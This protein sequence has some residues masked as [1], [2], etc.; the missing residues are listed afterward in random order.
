[1]VQSEERTVSVGD[2]RLSEKRRVA[3]E[4]GTVFRG[5]KKMEKW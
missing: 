2:K 4:A 3:A 5:E 1:M